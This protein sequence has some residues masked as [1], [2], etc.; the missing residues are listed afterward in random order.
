MTEQ[1]PGLQK[2]AEFWK[3]P[4]EELNSAEWEALCDGC[5]RCCLKKMQDEETGDIAWTRIVCRYLDQHAGRCTCYQ[6][7]QELVPDCLDVSAMDIMAKLQWMPATCAYRL[8]AEGKALYQW[9]PLLS[10]SRAAMI[11][12]GIAVGQQVLSEDNVHPDGWAEHII[13]W[14]DS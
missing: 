6:E 7:R 13:R 11:D 5:A 14:V 9:H 10:G 8:R 3:L 1:K 2:R 4:L 12:E